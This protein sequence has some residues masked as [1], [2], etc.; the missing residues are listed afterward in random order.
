MEEGRRADA[1][2]P[3]LIANRRRQFAVNHQALLVDVITVTHN[4][5]ETEGQ[6]TL[7][8][9]A[10]ATVE[11][12]LVFAVRHTQASLSDEIS[13]WQGLGQLRKTPLFNQRDLF[14]GLLDCHV[15][16]D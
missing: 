12:S 5:V 7:V 2:A 15:V 3:S 8:K 6:R 4:V 14:D 16:I 1:V 10:K 11:V 13:E 9:I